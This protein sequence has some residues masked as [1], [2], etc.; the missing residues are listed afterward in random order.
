M[1]SLSPLLHVALCVLGPLLALRAQ[2]PPP[3]EK[4]LAWPKLEAAA[5]AKLHRVQQALPKLAADDEKGF[6]SLRTEIALIGAA[7]APRLLKDLAKAAEKPEENELWIARLRSMLDLTATDPQHLPLVARELDAASAEVRLWCA[8]QLLAT[9]DP[10]ALSPA[11]ARYEKEKD[12][13]VRSTLLLLRCTLGDAESLPEI[14]KLLRKEWARWRDPA[15]RA[16]QGLRG[17]ATSD[18][19]LTRLQSSADEEERLFALRVLTS[20]GDKSAIDSI[21]SFLDADARAL[22]EAAVNALR[23]IVD[24]Q[25]PRY[26]VSVF[27]LVQLVEEWKKRLPS[28]KR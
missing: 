16:L 8:E 1:R 17:K 13:R 25:E 11:R 27:D 3:D 21:A 14:E 4:A 2:E 15:H 6:A 23:A 5:A 28:L 7:A 20:V 24:H 10:R 26:E 22:R 19:M 9:A 12:A 18:A